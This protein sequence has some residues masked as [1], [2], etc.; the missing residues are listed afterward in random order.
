MTLILPKGSIMV[1]RPGILRS[2]DKTTGVVQTATNTYSTYSDIVNNGTTLP[3]EHSRAALAVSVNR[4]QTSKRMANGR[5]R[6]YVIADKRT[7]QTSWT[8]LPALDKYTVDGKAGADAIEEFYNDT[9][10]QFILTIVPG[11]VL[12]SNGIAQI[13]KLTHHQVMFSD[14]STSVEK[15]GICN[16]CNVSVSLEEV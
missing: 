7:W 2:W 3:S 6:N 13:T 12:D 11:D 8:M 16:M 9:P 1:W 14:F 15:R 10:G 5:M 4:I